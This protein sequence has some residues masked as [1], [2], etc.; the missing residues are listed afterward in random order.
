MQIVAIIHKSA[1]LWV[2]NN[3]SKIY[4]FEKQV[5][6]PFYPEDNVIIDGYSVVGSNYNSS[7]GK[8]HIDLT[9]SIC[10]S[11][12]FVNDLITNMKKLGY[13]MTVIEYE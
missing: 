10:A 13:N 7:E 2:G 5:V 4:N 9:G 1:R 3:V 11:P 12:D 6:L 8:L